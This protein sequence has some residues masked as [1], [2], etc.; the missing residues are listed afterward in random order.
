MTPKLPDD[1]HEVDRLAREL[2]STAIPDD[3]PT[4]QNIYAIVELIARKIVEDWEREENE[5]VH[6]HALRINDHGS[7]PNSEAQNIGSISAEEI[8]QVRNNDP[9]TLIRRLFMKDSEEFLAVIK[10]GA[11]E[12]VE[13]SVVFLAGLVPEGP[14]KGEPFVIA[15]QGHRHPDGEILSKSVNGEDLLND[16][17]TPAEVIESLEALYEFA[18]RQAR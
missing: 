15:A 7:N 11:H 1:P 4:A 14:E 3:I 12:E 9:D 10:R 17:R 2:L 16:R 6:F 5:V 18:R 8:A 13:V